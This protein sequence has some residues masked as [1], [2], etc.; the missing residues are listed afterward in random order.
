MDYFFMFNAEPDLTEVR[1]EVSGFCLTE[2]W[3]RA[4]VTFFVVNAYF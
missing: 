4:D 3:Y 2:D 1:C